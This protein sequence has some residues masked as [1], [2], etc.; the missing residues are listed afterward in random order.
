MPIPFAVTKM[1]LT[2][3]SIALERLLLEV[4]RALREEEL[5]SLLLVLPSSSS[6]EL[7]TLATGKTASVDRGLTSQYQATTQ[8]SL[9]P[10]PTFL[11]V[12]QMM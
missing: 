7:S 6:G 8:P 9:I 10:K 4:A 3:P 11:V 12:F 1:V 5:R 2:S